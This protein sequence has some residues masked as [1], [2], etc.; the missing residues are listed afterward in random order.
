MYATKGSCEKYVIEIKAKSTAYPR[1]FCHYPI[2]NYSSLMKKVIFLSNTQLVFIGPSDLNGP[3]FDLLT[4]FQGRTITDY[5]SFSNA[6]LVLDRTCS[7]F[8]FDQFDPWS[9]LK[10][11]RYSWQRWRSIE[12][13]SNF[14][15]EE[16][17]HPAISK[18]MKKVPFAW[19]L[20]INHTK[21]KH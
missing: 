19:H 5:C 6:D 3:Q 7:G 9:E 4:Q 2:L 12:M 16:L 18:Q 14:N 10:L 15:V 1:C 8:G 17:L 13:C 20:V 21:I 11:Q